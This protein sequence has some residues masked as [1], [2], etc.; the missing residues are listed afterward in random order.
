MRSSSDGHC[1]L[2]NAA[3]H[4]ENKNFYVGTISN[5]NWTTSFFPNKAFIPADTCNTTFWLFFRLNSPDYIALL[6]CDWKNHKTQPKREKKEKEWRK[7]K[8]DAGMNISLRLKH[9][10]KTELFFWTIQ[11]LLDYRCKQIRG[12]GLLTAFRVSLQSHHTNN[13]W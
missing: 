8:I 6:D 12:F 13:I 3:D 11:L 9:M 10:F 7:K 4:Y 1:K 2:V 5:L